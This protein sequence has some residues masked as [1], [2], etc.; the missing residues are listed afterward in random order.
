MLY[1]NST[2]FCGYHGLTTKNMFFGFICSKSKGKLRLKIRNTEETLPAAPLRFITF[3]QAVN[4]TVI[5]CS[6]LIFCPAD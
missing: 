4:I 2:S 1:F 6:D 3:R 5:W